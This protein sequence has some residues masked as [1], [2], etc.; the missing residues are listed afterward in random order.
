MVLGRLSIDGNV[1]GESWER[2]SQMQDSFEWDKL[3]GDRVVE[4]EE[5]KDG[6]V[7]FSVDPEKWSWEAALVVFV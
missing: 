7:E 4:V 6:G 3:D 2:V 1:E 5:G